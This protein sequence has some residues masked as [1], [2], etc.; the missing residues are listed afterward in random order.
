MIPRG[1]DRFGPS[2]RETAFDRIGAISRLPLP[3]LTRWRSAHLIGIGGAGMSGIARLLLARGVAITGSDL[4][5]SRALD[6][7]RSETR[8]FVGHRAEQVDTPDAV[9]V[10]TAIP[11]DNPELQEARRRGI[12]VVTRAQV[13]AAL[14]EGHRTVAVAGTHGKTTTTSMITV[15]LAG[16]GTDPT[17]VVGGDLNEIGSGAG[18]GS[19]D[20]FVA[21][22]DES[23]GSFLL[24]HPDIALITNIEEDHLDFYAGREEIER[25]FAAFA[26]QAKAVV[27]WWDDPGV[28]RA[29]HGVPNVIREGSSSEYDVVISSWEPLATGSRGRVEVFGTSVDIELAVPGEH[30]VRH[31]AEALAVAGLL[32]LPLDRTAKALRAFTGVRRRFDPRGEAAGVRFVD[33]YA[34]HPSEVKVVLETARM[35]S[36]GRLVAVF[37]PHRYTRTASMWRALGES[38]AGAD[39]T[40]VTD[41]YPAGEAP[42]PGVTGKLLADALAE[43]VPG[44][45]VIYLP[46]RSDV[47]WLLAREVREGDL[48]VTMGAGDITMVGD[49]TLER[50]RERT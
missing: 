17:F 48:V 46:R 4:K 25:A 12:P 16:V 22:A 3:D 50:L 34:H 41:V 30:N 6:A 39:V 42:I 45:R 38:L 35:R 40:V 37:Q 2:D 33:D 9:V 14:T 24:L 27:A 11:P 20:I 21:E 32:G 44:K 26:K 43:A 5:D 1:T 10:S 29:L 8:I 36:G 19:G 49:E 18:V 47:A 15:M 31:A 13:L 28:R 23:D 7:L